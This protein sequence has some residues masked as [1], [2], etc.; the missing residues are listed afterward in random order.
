MRTP[1]TILSCGLGISFLDGFFGWGL[2]DG[3]YAL[4]G[5]TMIATLVWMWIIELKK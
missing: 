5:L 4:V 1:L 2:A 3:F